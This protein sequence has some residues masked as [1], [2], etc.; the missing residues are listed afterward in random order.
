M[1]DF[2]G[3]VVLTGVARAAARRASPAVALDGGGEI[4]SV[5]A[6]DGPVAASVYPWEIVLEPP[7]AAAPGSARNHVRGEVTTVTDV[8][9]RVRVAITAG[10]PLVAEVTAAAVADLGLRRGCPSWPPGRRRRRGWS[11]I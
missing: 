7:G 2:T 9:G 5:D 10:Q 8:G 4:A 6:G 3:A 1:A 11:P